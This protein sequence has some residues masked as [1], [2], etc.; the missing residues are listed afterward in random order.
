MTATATARKESPSPV[1]PPDSCS[2]SGTSRG[3]LVSTGAYDG[4]SLYPAR[5]RCLEQQLHSELC[6]L[7]AMGQEMQRALQ[8]RLAEVRM[9]QRERS[10][11]E[12]IWQKQLQQKQQRQR[13][14]QQNQQRHRANTT[15]CA[16]VKSSFQDHSSSS[17][18]RRHRRSRSHGGSLGSCSSSTHVASRPRHARDQDNS[19]SNKHHPLS[20]TRSR[21]AVGSRPEYSHGSSVVSRSHLKNRC[22]ANTENDDYH[23]HHQQQLRLGSSASPPPLPGKKKNQR[24]TE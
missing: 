4:V 7:G 21:Q 13:S 1:P 17:S 20:T 19:H 11:S 9:L 8:R 14:Q 22:A 24:M 10:Q 3:S 6:R 12:I 2:H 18:Q 15:A 16:S 23:Y 5:L